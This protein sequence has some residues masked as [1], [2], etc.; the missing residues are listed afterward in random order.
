[1]KKFTIL[2][3]LAVFSL[4]M[5]VGCSGNVEEIAPEEGSSRKSI[6]PEEKGKTVSVEKVEV[7]ADEPLVYL[8]VVAAEASSFD[9]TPDWA[10]EPN[11]MAPVDGDILTRW[12][13]DYTEG[14]QWIYFDLGGP[15]VVSDVIIRWERAYATDYKILVSNDAKNW[16]VVHHEPE[17]KA[18]AMEA[19]FAPVRARYVKIL[20]T[21][22][23]NDDWGISMWEVEIYGPAGENP[24]A[25]V[26]REAYLSKGEDDGKK[27][28]AEELIAKLSAPVIPI[29]EKPF[30]KGIVYTSW[31]ADEFLLP[32]S[33]LTLA[34]LKETGFDTI[35]IMVPAYQE[36]LDSGVIFTNDKPDGDTPTDESLKHAIETCHKLGLRV[37]IKPHVDPRTDEARVNIMPSEQWFDSYEELIMR[38]ARFSEENNVEL[39]SV[40]TELEATTFETWAPRWNQIIDKVRGVYKGVLT[41]SANWTEYK[42]VPFWDNVDFIGID[43]YF[44]LTN[45]DEPRMEDLIK[46]WESEADEIGEWLREKGLTEK[47]VIFTEIGYP[48]AQGANRQPWVAVSNVE[49]QQEQADCFRAMFDVLGARPWF[50]GYYIWQY[51]PQDRWSPLGFTVKGKKAEEVLKERL[52]K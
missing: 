25:T 51:F 16:Q 34:Y 49:D 45:S 23:I 40:G 36:D 1:M 15:R 20:G 14:P 18:G 41:Y 44:P 38:Y 26:T 13:S 19:G 47:G 50:K 37:M 3:F 17:G 30:Q 7:A 35:S 4:F 22:R 12:S 33:D 29:S 2:L 31:M 9:Q 43:A 28:E 42:E 32:V 39:F 24:D 10:P 8:N 5:T 46:A 27:K 21:E 48:S 11:P 52:E 6:V